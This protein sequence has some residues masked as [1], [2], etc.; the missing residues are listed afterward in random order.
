M[1]NRFEGKVAVVSG[2]GRGIGRAVAL[3]LAEERASVVV[4]D[5]GCDVDGTGS[6]PVPADQVVAEIRARGGAAVASYQDVSAMAGGEALVQKAVD[7]YHRLDVLVNSVGIRRDRLIWEMTP[8][9]FD[10]VIRGSLKAVFTPT[11]FACIL[12][13]QQRSGRIVNITSDAGMGAIGMSN[14]AAASEGIVGMTRTIAR[15]MGR[16]GITCNAVSP[17]AA[18]RL[19][20]GMVDMY[21]QGGPWA[22]NPDRRAGLGVPSPRDPREYWQGAGT[23]DD[24][25]N[26]A[27]LVAYLCSDASPNANGYVF[28]V[29]GGDVYLYTN[30]EVERAIYDRGLFSME[31]LD[32]LVPRIISYDMWRHRGWR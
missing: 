25:E 30:P 17:V 14:F 21:R 22:D 27:P 18:T 28:G 4:N 32:D 16:Y 10:A 24:P 11:K 1:G 8:E 13:R 26:V 19:S 15:D 9:D 31:A 3:L 20:S 12:F 6:S 5:L 7:T 23:P 29:R 2:G